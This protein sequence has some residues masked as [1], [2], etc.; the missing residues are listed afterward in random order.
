MK[1]LA[2]IRWLHCR[3]EGLALDAV[4]IALIWW[5]ALGGR[6]W[7]SAVVLSGATWL[8]YLADRL[9]DVRGDGLPPPTERHRFTKKYRKA[10]TITWVICF[11]VLVF[12]AHLVLPA[13]QIW[14]GWVIVL[15][16]LGYLIRLR[17]LPAGWTRSLLKRWAV[18]IVFAG[19]VT[20]MSRGVLPHGILL[21]FAASANLF[22]IS[23]FEQSGNKHLERFRLL[24][25]MSTL[26]FAI[27]AAILGEWPALTV[28][29]LGLGLLCLPRP[30]PPWLRTR[31]ACDL[32]VAL[33][34]LALMA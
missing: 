12:F 13:V 10:I 7:E 17:H 2:V 23:L 27:T 19:G 6:Q 21:F 14:A 33:A 22:L 11:S 15:L 3:I 18:A 30:F 32:V 24:A 8:T 5:W 28:G 20:F 4:F 25:L 31:F 29:G 26:G 1:P 16:I 9:S 34:G